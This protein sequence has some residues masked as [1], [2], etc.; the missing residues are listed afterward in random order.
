[1]IK[2]NTFHADVS[3]NVY[4]SY[5]DL[6]K[7]SSPFNLDT[8]IIKYVSYD[9]KKVHFNNPA[10]VVMWEDGT[11]TVVKCQPGDEY[12]AEKGLAMCFMKKIL[13]N[14]SN[15]NNVLN[16]YIEEYEAEKNI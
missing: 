14:K 5:I 3:A 1:M 11:K 13:G 16:K 6:L 2:D 12:D 8:A 10:T 9:I 15:F 7:Y 4:P